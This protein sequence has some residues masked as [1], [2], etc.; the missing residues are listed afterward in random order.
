LGVGLDEENW[1]EILSLTPDNIQGNIFF[2]TRHFGEMLSS[3]AN[4]HFL[5]GIKGIKIAHL[6]AAKRS[7]QKWRG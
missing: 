3:T 5:L 2:F 1:N 7:F 4:Q 6:Y